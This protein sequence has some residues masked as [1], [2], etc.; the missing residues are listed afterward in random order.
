MGSW[1]LLFKTAWKTGLPVDAWEVDAHLG[2]YTRRLLVNQLH[3]DVVENARNTG[4]TRIWLIGISLGGLGSLLYA[5]E[6][7][8]AIS[9]MV[10]LAP[11]LGNSSLVREIRKAGGVAN[12]KPT[13]V[14]P[15]D[16][17]R[18]LWQWLQGYLNPHTALPRLYLGFGENDKFAPSNRLLA[19]ILPR[20]QVFI[21]SGGHNWPTWKHLW[22]RI[23][24]AG[25]FR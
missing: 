10:V 24:A 20:E 22:Q 9:G 13:A 16:Y 23:L 25:F 14:Q 17:Q 15:G 1:Q 5:R 12:W 8:E 3:T 18:H 2:Y 21:A 6:H 11:F 4:Y 7:P 19:E